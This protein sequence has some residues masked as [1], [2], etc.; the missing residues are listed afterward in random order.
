MTSEP[1]LLYLNWKNKDWKISAM[2][3]TESV[4]LLLKMKEI[5]KE[6]KEVDMCLNL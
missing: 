1:L 3:I 4:V 2:L 6:Y 5:K